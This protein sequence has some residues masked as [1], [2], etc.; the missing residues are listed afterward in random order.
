MKYN[1]SFVGVED[2]IFNPADVN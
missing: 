2:K 1:A